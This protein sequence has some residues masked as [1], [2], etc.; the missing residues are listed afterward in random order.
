[1]DQATYYRNI[2]RSFAYFR[3]AAKK[4][5]M[6]VPL[7]KGEKPAIKEKGLLFKLKKKIRGERGVKVLKARPLKI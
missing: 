4:N 7:K 2:S 1:M 5:S 3:E 6:A